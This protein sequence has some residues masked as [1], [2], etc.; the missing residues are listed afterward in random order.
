MF[1]FVQVGVEG[2]FS[3]TINS[4]DKS[5]C[6]SEIYFRLGL[7]NI[8]ERLTMEAMEDNNTGQKSARFYKRLAECAMLKGEKVLAIRYIQKLKATIFYRAWA[9]R[10]EQ[11]LNDPAHTEA[12][13]DWKIKPLEMKDDIFFTPATSAYFLYNLL[14]N[15]PH[16]AK[17]FHYLAAYLLL[18]RDL[19]RLYSFLSQ[20]RPEGE[21]GTHIYEAT[22]L[23]LFLHNKDEF[24]KVMSNNNDLT[25]RFDE[26]GRFYSAGTQNPQKA[27]ELFGHSYWFYY[28]Y[29]N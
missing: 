29:C 23:Y 27:K 20:Y 14:Y 17:V 3:S 19:E 18:D 13:A 16:N 2:L 10:A 6:N 8:S 7:V 12:L 25:H 24:N 15:N 28:Y 11:F 9:L 1:N 5:I 4:Q 26:F 22:L 21:L